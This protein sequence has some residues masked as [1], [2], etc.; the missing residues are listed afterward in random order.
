MFDAACRLARREPSIVLESHT[1]HTLLALAEARHGV[2]II[3]SGVQTHRYKVRLVRVMHE[4]KPL[5]EPLAVLWD[6]R[7]ALSGT[8]QDFCEELAAYAKDLYP[9]TRSPR[10][11]GRSTRPKGTSRKKR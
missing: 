9:I 4:G 6:N 5:Q 10:A 8:A 3:P 1:P 2:A 11:A 7:R